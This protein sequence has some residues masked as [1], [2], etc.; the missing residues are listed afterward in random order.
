MSVFIHYGH[1]VYSVITRSVSVLSVFCVFTHP[2]LVCC[3]VCILCQNTAYTRRLLNS[4]IAEVEQ[5]SVQLKDSV[6][7]EAGAFTR[8]PLCLLP[9]VTMPR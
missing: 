1:K 5:L 2:V 3:V 8:L 4:H 6:T 7:T 9:T